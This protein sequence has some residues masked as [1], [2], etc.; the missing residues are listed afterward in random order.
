M[1]FTISNSSKRSPQ[2]LFL[3]A[4]TTWATSTTIPYLKLALH[5]S[6]LFYHSYFYNFKPSTLIQSLESRHPNPLSSPLLSKAPPQQPITQPIPSNTPV[7]YSLQFVNQFLPLYG[8][9]PSWHL[10]TPPP[11]QPELPSPQLIQVIPTNGYDFNPLLSLPC[12]STKP[13]QHCSTIIIIDYTNQ[14]SI[15]TFY[16]FLYQTHEYSLKGCIFDLFAVQLHIIAFNVDESDLLLI[17]TPEVVDFCTQCGF[18]DSKIHIYHSTFPTTYS[19]LPTNTP[20]KPF[21]SPTNINQCQQLNQTSALLPKE[22]YMIIST[23]V[24]DCI[25]TTFFEKVVP[26]Y[27]YD[28]NCY[29]NT[30]S[31]W[32]KNSNFNHNNINITYSGL[33]SNISSPINGVY[34]NSFNYKD[35]FNNYNNTKDEGR[36]STSSSSNSHS[37]SFTHSIINHPPNIATSLITP[38]KPIK[39]KGLVCSNL[40]WPQSYSLHEFFHSA[41]KILLDLPIN[42]LQLVPEQLESLLIPINP[43]V[44]N[45]LISNNSNLSSSRKSANSSHHNDSEDDGQNNIL[46]E[47]HPHAVLIKGFLHRYITRLIEQKSK[48]SNVDQID[49]T[50]NST[51]LSKSKSKPNNEVNKQ[52]KVMNNL[53]H[54]YKNISKVPY[55]SNPLPPT[56]TTVTTPQT[57]GSGVLL[58]NIPAPVFTKK[59]TDINLEA[60]RQLESSEISTDLSKFNN[61]SRSVNNTDDLQQITST[62]TTHSQLHQLQIQPLAPSSLTSLSLL[63]LDLLMLLLFVDFVL[64]A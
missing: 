41:Q 36:T 45:G 43:H 56:I 52:Q 15:N 30:Y 5:N 38:L 1:S 11:Q 10:P 8:L 39:Q 40:H 53:T 14:D 54:R 59:L 21:Q 48:Q 20:L 16:Q 12:Y 29:I 4:T 60:Q 24:W 28:Y 55:L 58:V 27:N 25:F 37:F 57:S 7:D 49:T 22:D 2:P 26:Q 47:L 42:T 23:G 31:N 61:K 51:M 17:D 19:N 33:N 44:E 32:M 64:P 13:V 50:T 9:K 34:G 62:Q 6:N 18:L 35:S 3:L 46:Q 63:R